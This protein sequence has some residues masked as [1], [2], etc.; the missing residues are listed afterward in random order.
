MKKVAVPLIGPLL[1]KIAPRIG[2]RVLLEPQ[3][4][5]AGQITFRN[6]SRSYFR[7][8][9]IGINALG[10]SEISKDKDYA[11][12]FMHRM[13]Y[14]T[15]PGKTFFKE[16]FR[17]AL[18]SKRGADAAVA[19]ATKIGFP[20]VAK[21]NSGSQGRGVYIAKNELELRKSLKEI[22]LLDRV[23]LVQRVVLGFDYRIVVLDKNVISAY[24][25]LPLS[26]VGDG[27]STIMQLLQ[28]KQK[29]FI[30]LDRD[31]HIDMK[32]P[33]IRRKLLHQHMAMRSVP[34][35]GERIMLLDNANLSSGGDA[36][37]VTDT[38]H[39]D[40]KR[41]AVKLTRDMGLRLC[42]VDIMTER[43]IALK[44]SKYSIIEINSA[45]GLDHYAQSGK[46]Q[47]KI[48]EDLYLQ[49]LKQMS[50]R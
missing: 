41:M 21:P 47:E 50:S 34:A 46:A 14:P 4:K 9:S 23:A 7:F 18:H 25:R 36:L 49:V 27:R 43:D 10:A 40:Y 13:G 26:V 29:E 28:K 6:G 33:R 30:A 16:D 5:V 2:A 15:I 20:V 11:N 19:Y 31:T 32:D 48:V 45:P 24:Q 39:A 12:F 38:L 44:P 3:W 22:F 17:K 37:D 42:G 35:K 8:N 1:K